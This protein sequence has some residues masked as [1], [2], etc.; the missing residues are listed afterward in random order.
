MGLLGRF[1]F[2]VLIAHVAVG[3]C[4]SATFTDI[5]SNLPS[6]PVFPS[7]TL[8]AS[9]TPKVTSVDPLTEVREIYNILRNI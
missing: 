1:L 5:Y 8:S 4:P 2:I 6:A 7:S 3:A 9:L